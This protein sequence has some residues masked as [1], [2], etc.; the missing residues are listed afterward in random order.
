MREKGQSKDSIPLYCRALLF[1]RGLRSLIDEVF[2]APPVA[3]SFRILI[4]KLGLRA[5]L[6]RRSYKRCF[7]SY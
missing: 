4:V 7:H 1:E 3:L 5:K 6:D 2:N